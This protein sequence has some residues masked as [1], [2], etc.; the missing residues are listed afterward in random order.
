MI[1]WP[2]TPANWPNKPVLRIT[3]ELLEASGYRIPKWYGIAWHDYDLDVVVFMWM[4]FNVLAGW[5]MKLRWM[6]K[7]GV[8]YNAEKGVYKKGYEQGQKDGFAK[9]YEE[10]MIEILTRQYKN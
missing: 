5:Y 2:V 9:G 4:P 1:T 8:L 7:K 6:F 3:R 10:W